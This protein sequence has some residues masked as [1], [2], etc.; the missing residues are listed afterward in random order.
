MNQTPEFRPIHILT[1]D[2]CGSGQDTYEHEIPESTS[3]DGSIDTDSLNWLPND[4]ERAG[5][6]STSIQFLQ[7]V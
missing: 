6:R 1:M 7:H 5:E 3:M 4:I 2:Y